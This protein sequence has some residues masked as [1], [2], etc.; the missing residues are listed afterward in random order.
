[1]NYPFHYARFIF[2]P[3]ALVGSLFASPV[4]GQE[5]T[6]TENG[7]STQTVETIP[8]VDATSNEA[9]S[10]SPTVDNVATRQSSNTPEPDAIPQAGVTPPADEQTPETVTADEGTSPPA[11]LVESSVTDTPEL[12]QPIESGDSDHVVT[13]SGI[14]IKY[15]VECDHFH[16]ADI[17]GS[18]SARAL[19]HDDL[20]K[21][22]E[23]P[24]SPEENAR[25]ADGQKLY[26]RI[27]MTVDYAHQNA[28]K[29][30]T[31]AGG[32]V[33]DIPMSLFYDPTAQ[34]S[35][36]VP[37]AITTQ[38]TA[39][40]VSESLEI[41]GLSPERSENS[42]KDTTDSSASVEA[43]TSL[44]ADIPASAPTGDEQEPAPEDSS[45]RTISVSADASASSTGDSSYA[46]ETIP[47]NIPSSA[48]ASTVEPTQ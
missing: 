6:S 47:R 15:Y 3:V 39:E 16:G 41:A 46:S 32:T 20:G 31:D 12:V 9:L 8:P 36:T 11:N 21:K 26:K 23:M 17:M 44:P 1:M 25:L 37:Q 40:T 45:S 43:T 33:A 18:T 28:I 2:I 4:L 19:C 14:M 29:K 27:L 48:D 10:D 24:I 5:A 38:D 42:V 13:A 22:Y 30:I 34:A 7:S 35:Q